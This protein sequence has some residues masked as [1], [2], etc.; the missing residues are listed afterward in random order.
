MAEMIIPGTYIEVRAEGLTV[1]G[2]ISISNVAVIGTARR[3]PVGVVVTPANFAEARDIFGAYDPFDTP[4]E[5]GAPLTLVRALELAYTNGAQNVFAVRVGATGGN[6]GATSVYTLAAGGGTNVR[7]ESLYPGS[8]YDTADVKVETGASGLNVTFTT[9]DKRLRET[10]R[11]VPAAV[12]DF[13]A[14]INGTNATYPYGTKSSNRGG[15]QLFTLDATGAVG[16]VATGSATVSTGGSNGAN[17]AAGDYRDAL[18]LLLNEDVHIV[19]LAGQ[20]A[21]DL[22]A[23]LDAHC[24]NASTDTIKHDRIGIIGGDSDAL[25]AVETH[26][27]SDRII[28]CAPGILVNDSATGSQVALPGSYTAAA[29]AGLIASLPAHFSPTNKSLRVSGVTTRYN[30]TQLEQI[31]LARTLVL[32]DRRGAIKVV[33]GITT[34]SDTAFKQITTRRIVDYA[35]FGVR[36]SCD[37]FIGKLNND[38]VRQ[39]MK[40]TINSFLADM[41]DQE[42]LI[43][44]DLAV[45]ATRAQQ[46]RGIAQVTMTLRPTFSID[47]IR[48]VMNLE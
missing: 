29:V 1:P 10:W 23:D 6:A 31:L 3:G 45:T 26:P 13:V 36:S 24:Q 25:N 27:D 14:T 9:A 17:A 5:T 44:Y 30:G 2:Q 19:V 41:V 43:S 48:V 7:V 34:A 42:M 40:G 12:D 22:G 18:D 4:E 20:T 46:I 47:Y 21:A 39:A 15:S 8:G 37:P 38:R 11:D 33:Q 16:D 32:E 35:K 28:F